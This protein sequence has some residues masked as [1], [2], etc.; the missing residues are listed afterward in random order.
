MQTLENIVL[1]NDNSTFMSLTELLP[2]IYSSDIE[3]ASLDKPKEPGNINTSY[4][5]T[6]DHT[7]KNEDQSENQE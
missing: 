6:H 2:H 4:K 1:T 5:G 3:N 7:F